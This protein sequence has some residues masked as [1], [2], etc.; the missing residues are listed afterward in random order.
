[1]TSTASLSLPDRFTSETMPDKAYATVHDQVTGRSCHVDLK[2]FSAF[3]D[4][5]NALFGEDT[6]ADRPPIQHVVPLA[7]EEAPKKQRGRPRK[8]QPEIAEAENA[9]KSEVVEEAT[10]SSE[11]T[12]AAATGTEIAPKKRRGRPPKIK[13]EE[14]AKTEIADPATSEPVIQSQPAPEKT[15]DPEVAPKRRGRPPKAKAE[16]KPAPAKRGPKPKPAEGGSLVVGTKEVIE[17]QGFN[18]VLN[19]DQTA[20][21]VTLDD[22]S[23]FGTIKLASDN[24]KFEV[25]LNGLPT[26]KH[27]SLVGGQVRVALALKP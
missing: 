6:D 1:M 11:T 4:A 5:L 20:Y 26:T 16:V 12:I 23:N 22:G 7:P 13:P 17:D 25:A 27:S 8:V 3:I 9:A 10:Q 19:E 15:A 2:I 24:K 18:L 21:S 14:V